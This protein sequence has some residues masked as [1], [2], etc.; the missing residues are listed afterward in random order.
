MK[1]YLP[2]TLVGPLKTELVYRWRDT[3]GVAFGAFVCNFCLGEFT[4]RLGAVAS[5]HTKSCGC[6]S[7]QW[8]IGSFGNLQHGLSG[9]KHHARWH[10][11]MARCYNPK[12]SRYKHWGGRGIKVCERWHDATLYKEDIDKQLEKQGLTLEDW[13]KGKNKYSV[14]RKNNDGDYEPSNI[15]FATF[16]EQA[17]N[18]RSTT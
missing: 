3:Q 18:R 8:K 7:T 6:M 14:D 10:S 15:R 17:E 2:G 12:H 1:K 11:M 5:G 16:Q 13:G 4:S 9:T